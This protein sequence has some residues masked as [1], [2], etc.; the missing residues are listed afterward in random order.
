M[1]GNGNGQGR[2]KSQ[3]FILSRHGKIYCIFKFAAPNWPTP[4]WGE[5]DKFFETITSVKTHWITDVKCLG[6]P[7]KWRS[8]QTRRT[9]WLRRVRTTSRFRSSYLWLLN[10]FWHCLHAPLWKFCNRC[11]C[12]WATCPWGQGAHN[13][14]C[15]LQIQDL[16]FLVSESLFTFPTGLSLEF[17]QFE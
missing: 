12:W 4:N 3:K 17:L 8:V 5:Y 16:K 9:Q 6:I 14:W 13:E 15:T 7:M 1:H 2:H 11:N 10:H